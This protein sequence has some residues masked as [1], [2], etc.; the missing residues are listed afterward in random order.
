[1][2][3]TKKSTLL[4]RARKNKRMASLID[5]H[6]SMLSLEIQFEREL[7]RRNESPARFAKK[8]GSN[9][10]TVS[11]DLHGGL[12]KAKLERVASMA[13]ALDCDLVTI[14]LPR[15]ADERKDR[16][17]EVLGFYRTALA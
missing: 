10:S 9:R 14:I 13:N 5:K 6:R 11:R 16:L 2:T 8:I 15:E 4:E 1:M 12:S 17:R 7:K 3:K